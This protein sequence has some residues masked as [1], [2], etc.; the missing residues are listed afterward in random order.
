MQRRSSKREDINKSA[1]LIVSE[2]TGGDRP[3]TV[4]GKNAYAVALGRSGGLKVGKAR[5]AK[6]ST[7]RRLEIAKKATQARWG[8]KGL[9]L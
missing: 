3:Q 6:L 2:A 9:A 1:S 7:E 5:A 4:D 8:N